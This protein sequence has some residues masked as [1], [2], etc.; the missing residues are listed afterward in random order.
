MVIFDIELDEDNDMF[1]RD[2]DIA[3]VD[4]DDALKQRLLIHLQFLLGEWFLDI[5]EGI[6]YVQTIFAQA[7][8]IDDIYLIFRDEIK[9]IE[10]VESITSLVL[11]PDTDERSLRVEFS[12]NQGSVTDTVEVP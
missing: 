9:N 3:M 11:T 7:T 6:P 8:D 12:V 4:E 2:G 5:R 1:L 10:G